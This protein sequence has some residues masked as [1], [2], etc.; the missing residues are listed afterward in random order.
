M[1]FNFLSLNLTITLSRFDI[2]WHTRRSSVITSWSVNDKALQ[3]IC[4]KTLLWT[5]LLWY[6]AFLTVFFSNW[7]LPEYN[8]K[9]Q[10]L[11]TTKLDLSSSY[12]FEKFSNL[13]VSSLSRSTISE[14][15]TSSSIN[16][17][18]LTFSIWLLV[19][20]LK[21]FI[22]FEKILKELRAKNNVIAMAESDT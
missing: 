20:T 4:F 6:Y 19:K 21:D 1:C 9:L 2:W 5:S 13:S 11:V 3:I 15:F 8:G 14:N 17:S 10:F 7:K 16:S 18:L 12:F 22:R